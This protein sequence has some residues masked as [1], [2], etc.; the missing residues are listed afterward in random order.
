QFTGQGVEKNNDDAKRTV[1][2]KSNK[3]DSV[4]DVLCTES[5]Q[6]D[7][8]NCQRQKNCYTKRNLEYWDET[9][10]RQR[11]ER[12]QLSKPIV[13]TA[14]VN[15]TVD[16]ETCS[17]ADYSNFTVSQLRQKV[18]EMGLNRQGLAKMKK[19]ELINLLQC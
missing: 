10:K 19:N 15:A 3:W 4:K 9:I 13:I 17:R 16:A 5:R 2:Q 8:K 12:R 1:F 6:W 14:D 11:K 18:R 7:L